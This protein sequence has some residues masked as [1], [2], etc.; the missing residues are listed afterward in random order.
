MME[1]LNAVRTALTTT[2]EELVN[3]ISIF[4]MFVEVPITMLF[5]TTL[6]NID[7]TKRNKFI[8]IVSLSVFSLLTRFFIP[9]PYG[10][11]LNIIFMTSII[12]FLFKT[13]FLKS[14]LCVFVPLAINIVLE[15]LLESIYFV[16][17]E[18]PC[19]ILLTIPIYRFSIM[20]IIYLSIYIAY[21]ICKKYKFN[22]TLFE[23]INSHT[24]KLILF[25]TILS[26]IIIASQF[27]LLT[28]YNDRL[29][30]LMSLVNISSLLAYFVIS[31]S[32]IIKTTQLEIS[33]QNLQETRLYNKTLSILYDN[34]R[35]F[36]HDFSN[37]L[38]GIGGY[39][40]TEDLEGLKKYYSDL[41][42]D[43][44]ITNNLSAL[45]PDTINNPSI[46]NLLATKYH[47]A[48]EFGIKINLEIFLDLN[49]LNIK[50]YDFTRIIGILMDNAIEAAKVC[51]EKVINL[52]IRNDQNKNRQVVIIENTYKN[53]DVNL[54]LIFDKGVTSK[55]G[56]TGLGLW[57]VRE[58]LKKNENLNLF[59]TKNDKYFRQQFEMYNNASREG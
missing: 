40:Y 14:L 33:E 7:Y 42:S 41:L 1:T 5:F 6:F 57:K 43:C 39:I 47:I 11:F 37:I 27:F 25:N 26:I 28:Y 48:D 46:Y 2:N 4:L 12:I 22:I 29:P 49:K 8:Y 21:R 59:T 36:K 44:Q 23:N 45:N 19:N 15:Y 30:L 53:K 20:L 17:L 58:I 16:I 34:M 10:T 50:I 24:K 3:T 13:N 38:T 52:I 51:D 35:A 18:I 55:T 31:I 9:T 32:M 54:D 56:N